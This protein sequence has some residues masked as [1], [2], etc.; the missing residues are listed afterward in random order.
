M[1]KEK[2]ISGNPAAGAGYIQAPSWRKW[3]LGLERTQE[4]LQRLGDPQKRLSFVHVAGTNG[5]GSFCAMLESVLRAAGYKTGLYSSPAIRDMRDQIRINGAWIPEEAMDRLTEQIRREAD[6]MADHPSQFEMLTALAMLYFVEEQCGIVVMEVGL[7]GITDATNVI[8]TPELAVLTNIGIDHTDYLGET[9]AEIAEKKAGIIKLQGRVVCY[10]NCPEV[11]RVIRRACQETNS[12][13]TAADFHKIQLTEQSL[14]GQHFV[15]SPGA[16]EGYEHATELFL[17]LAG[18]FQLH[19]AALVLTAVE[20]LNRNG[21]TIPEEAVVRGFAEVQWPARFEIL[22]EEP[23]FIL[24]GGHN[25]QCAEAVADSLRQL[26]PVEKPVLLTGMLADKEYEAVLDVILPLVSDCI[27][28]EPANERALPAAEL[29][30]VIRQKGH[31]A[32]AAASVREA[33]QM[34]MDTGRPVFAF[35]SLYLAGEILKL[36]EE[37]T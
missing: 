37:K 28:T 12:L 30:E 34:A 31:P 25:L 23:L 11:M 22:S 32:K 35:G 10:P 9:L 19:N 36:Y 29:A 5:K 7:G 6:R 33:V 18:T 24:D 20:E 4:L 1:Q 14:A 13:L 8:D 15:W 21:R 3:K 16:E 2:Q 26:L 17:P 27:C